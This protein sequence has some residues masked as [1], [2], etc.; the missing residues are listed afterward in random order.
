M[1]AGL[2]LFSIR[3]LIQTEDA[4]LDT[5]KKLKEMGYS[6]LQY[7]GAPFDAQIIKRVSEATDMPVV[8]TH[9]PM[10]RILEETEQLME[11]HALFGCKNIGLGMMPLADIVDADKFKKTVE[12][13]NVAGEKMQKNGFKFFYH[14]HHYE[15]MK[16][17]GENV[18]IMDYMLDNAPY[19]NFTA[20]THWLQRGGVDVC[21]MLK[22]MQGRVGCV[23]FKDYQLLCNEE[24][25]VCESHFAPVGDGTLNF[26][27]IA[28]TVKEIGT[29]HVLVEQDDACKFPNALELVERSIKYIKNEL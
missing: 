14:H 5:A 20:D 18:T 1:N 24:T 2:N 10:Q 12:N 7:S 11:E 28:E 22:K 27:K 19:I 23:H 4:F 25:G 13:L 17:K 29:E 16:V 15:F 6:S 21:D 9:V 8:L 3:D 26:K